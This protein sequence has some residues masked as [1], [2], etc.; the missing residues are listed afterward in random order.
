MYPHASSSPS[1]QWNQ[2]LHRGHFLI[3]L[4]QAD[5]SQAHALLGHHPRSHFTKMQDLVE[6]GWVRNTDDLAWTFVW[7]PFAPA[8]KITLYDRF[9]EGSKSV[10]WWLQKGGRN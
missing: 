9:P 6:N 2:A 7:D 4:T 8:G 5:E 1:S 3:K 10:E